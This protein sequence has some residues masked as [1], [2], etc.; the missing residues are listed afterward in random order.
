MEKAC[1]TFSNNDLS[2]ELNLCRKEIE[3]LEKE[4]LKKDKVIFEMKE[5]NMHNKEIEVFLITFRANLL[6]FTAFCT[7]MKER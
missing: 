6:R 4:L 5:I 3:R 2:K 7:C 1:T